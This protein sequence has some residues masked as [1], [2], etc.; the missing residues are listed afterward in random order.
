MQASLKIGVPPKSSLFYRENSII[1]TI[2]FGGPSLF[3]GN[4]L[5]LLLGELLAFSL[6]VFNCNEMCTE[7]PSICGTGTLSLHSEVIK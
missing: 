1:F 3:F 6:W 7:S 5:I 2:H 4:T